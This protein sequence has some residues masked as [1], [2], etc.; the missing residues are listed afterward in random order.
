MLKRCDINRTTLYR[1]VKNGKIIVEVLPSGRYSYSLTEKQKDK[2]KSSLPKKN[3]IYSRV[4]TSSQKENLKRQTE[5]IKSFCSNKGIIVNDVYSEIASALN[6]NRKMYRRLFREVINGEVENIII[7]YKD[8]LLRIGFDDFVNLCKEKNVNLITIDESLSE[9]KTTHKE[10][11]SDM[12]SII[13]HF[14]ARIYSAR[15]RK[16]IIETIKQ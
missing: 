14:S 4:S 8:R 11:V 1:W 5:R 9:E 16:K 6:Y 13:H 3:I 12:I 10:I 15:K 2:I 7:E